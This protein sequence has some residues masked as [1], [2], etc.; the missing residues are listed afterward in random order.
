V[1]YLCK[2]ND[3]AFV[4][5]SP[6]LTDKLQPLDV[7]VFGPLKAAWRRILT[8]FKARVFVHNVR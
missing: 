6:N 3:F 7:G 2:A 4:W 8:N 1:I 5:L